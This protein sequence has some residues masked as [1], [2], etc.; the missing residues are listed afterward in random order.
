MNVLLAI[1][2]LSTGGA[3][4]FV[5]RLARK[6]AEQ[7]HT[8]YLWQ[9]FYKQNNHIYKAYLSHSN[10][11]EFPFDEGKV[12][13]LRKN[14]KSAKSVYLKYQLRKLVKKLK[15]DVVNSHLFESNYFIY[16]TLNIPH[17]ISMHGSYEYYQKYPNELKTF[18][19]SI[20][21][22]ACIQEIYKKVQAI[23]IVSDDNLITIPANQ[24]C[25]VKK[26]YLGFDRQKKSTVNKNSIITL[27]LLA[28]G[29][30]GKG[31]AYL[32]DS[33]LILKKKFPFLRLKLGYTTTEYMFLIKERYSLYSSDIIWLENVSDVSEFYSNVDL[34][35]FPSLL[36]ESLPNTI[37]ESLAFN[38]PV[39]TTDVGDIPT[40]LVSQKNELAGVLIE[41]N[42]QT[43][44]AS[45]TSEI[46]QLIQN[47][48]TYRA[49]VSFT[50]EA[51]RK[52]DITRCALEYFSIFEKSINAKT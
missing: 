12:D 7:G 1:N 35:V 42:E 17:V 19:N 22:S 15:I 48:V 2:N 44:T 18:N 33:F 13:Y 27:G 9:L 49:L 36:N 32:L 26:I 38:I 3:E 31:W 23:I 45:L 24:V 52:F 34:T 30:E 37:I 29:Q 40:M 21:F 28:R 43:L 51:F 4:T 5:C 14:E 16:R 11:H 50:E 25:K 41:Q 39:I 6:L 47:E 46:E 10:I 20:D 8:I